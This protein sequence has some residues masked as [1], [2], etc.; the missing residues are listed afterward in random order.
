VG[1]RP[2]DPVL[3][4]QLRRL[5]IEPEGVPTAAQWTVLI[6]RLND[7]FQHTNDDR[8]MLNRSL[9]LSTSE[10]DT[11]RR[12]VESQ[13]DRLSGV[14]GTIGEALSQFGALIQTEGAT[15]QVSLAK[16]AFAN[17]LQLI[18]DESKIDDDSTGE[19]SLIRGNL[20]RLADQLIVLLSDTAERAAIK[21]ELEVARAVQQLL[22]PSADDIQREGFEVASYFQPAAECGGDWW[23]VNDLAAG[24]HLLMVG[25]VTGH[26]VSSAIITGAAKAACELAIEVTAGTLDP[27]RL[28]ALMNSAIHRT[29]RERVMMSCNATIIDPARRVLAM[30]NAGHPNP[31]LVRQG[32]V[33]PLMAEGA[34]LGASADP[35]YRPIE[36]AIEPGDVL[37]CFTDGIVECENPRGE[38]FTERRLRAVIQRAAAA[39]GTSGPGARRAASVRDAVVAALTSFREDTEQGDDLTLV[40]T[41]FH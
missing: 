39:R 24:K 22:V 17:R 32:I 18:L 3:A 4:R 40:V 8:A 30:A 7:H 2:L 14:V 13:R 31:V 41:A 23:T 27:P 6:D 25:D 20:V 16:Q 38:Q 11:L 26:G 12:R 21:K 19:V 5:E 36:L 29:A 1:V 34:P 35:V 37:A 33:H 28:L 9:E 10:M 15:G